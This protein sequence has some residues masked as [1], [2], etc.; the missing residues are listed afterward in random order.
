MK[1]L[2]SQLGSFWLFKKGKSLIVHKRFEY[3]V[4]MEL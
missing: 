3:S 4:I 1:K 2:Q